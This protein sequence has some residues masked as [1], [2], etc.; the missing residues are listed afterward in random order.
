MS[1]LTGEIIEIYV[2]TWTKM[3]KVR[4]GGDYM[5][6]P[7]QFLPNAKVGDRI[8]IEGGVAIAILENEAKKE[9]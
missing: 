1:P 6:V 9:D 4:V 3:A 7:L 8:L 5:H 2:D